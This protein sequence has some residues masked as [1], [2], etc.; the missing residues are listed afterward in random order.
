MLYLDH[1]RLRELP[2]SITP[3]TTY[4]YSCEAAQAGLNTALVA[5]ASGE[6]FIKITGEVGTGKTLLAR[7]LLGMLGGDEWHAAYIPNPKIGPRTLLDALAEELGTGLGAEADE[8]HLYRALNGRLIKLAAEGRRALLLIDEAQAMPVQTLE[9][10]RLLGNLETEK[11]K[12]LQVVLFGQPELDEKLAQPGIRQLRQRIT[13]EHCLDAM[14][15][16]EVA[17]YLD[18]RL[19]IAGLAGDTL[20]TDRAVDLI[21]QASG[22]VPR[23]I[24]VLAHKAMLLAWGRGALAVDRAEVRG[25]IADTASARMPKSFFSWARELFPGSMTSPL[26]S[27]GRT[28]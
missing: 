3:D 26:S 22:G 7:K 17:G 1:W 11:R 24:N 12:L 28:Q 21:H 4:Y 16:D 27:G 9:T 19:R 10:V 13:F 5:I 6:G 15:L 23:L 18:H 8:H 2:F 14:T 25:A 20:F